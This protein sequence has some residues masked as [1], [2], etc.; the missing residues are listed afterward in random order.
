ME[1]IFDIFFQHKIETLPRCGLKTRQN[2]TDVIDH[3]NAVI[4]GYAEG[5]YQFQLLIDTLALFYHLSSPRLIGQCVSPDA[6][7]QLALVAAINYHRAQKEA[8]STVSCW[9]TQ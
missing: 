1:S 4:S 3:L 6:S 5:E 2:R 9:Q 8:N 7:C